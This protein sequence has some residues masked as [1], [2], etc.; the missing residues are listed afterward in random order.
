MITRDSIESA[1]RF[2]EF[3]DEA[4]IPF[5]AISREGETIEV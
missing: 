1:W 4:H 2:K 3:T 5:W